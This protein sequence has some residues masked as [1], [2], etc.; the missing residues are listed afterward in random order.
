M[1]KE[2]ELFDDVSTPHD[3]DLHV[4]DKQLFQMKQKIVEFVSNV[5][6]NVPVQPDKSAQD[7][8]DFHQS[9]SQHG[10][11][12]SQASRSSIKQQTI[13]AGLEAKCKALVDAQEA[14][15]QAKIAK[16][17]EEKRL[18]IQLKAAQQKTDLHKMEEKIAKV[19][20]MEKVYKIEEIDQE[21]LSGQSNASKNSK[22]TSA[23]RVSNRSSVAKRAELAGLKAEVEAKMKTQQSE[24][25]AE[26]LKNEAS[27]IATKNTKELAHRIELINLEKKIAK[28]K[29]IGKVINE[30]EASRHKHVQS[31]RGQLKDVSGPSYRGSLAG[32]KE[33][34]ARFNTDHAN[35]GYHTG[36]SAHPP[37]VNELVNLIKQQA[38]PDVEIDVFSGDL[39]E[40]TYF[41]T[42]FK[43]IVESSIN[44]QTARLNRLIKY[45]SG[46]AK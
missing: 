38:A 45:T 46:E 39:P 10:S 29:A 17:D 11:A 12:Y 26:L 30:D 24:I 1:T 37:L 5:E 9:V 32:K 13:I 7:D 18:A 15:L 41:I 19:K 36:P 27:A 43:E 35:L 42:N 31:T 22:S 14:E 21:K 4:F 2:R 34:I 23:S 40:Y 33:K 28:E 3:N 8:H 16:V 6:E 44:G 25:K 20:A